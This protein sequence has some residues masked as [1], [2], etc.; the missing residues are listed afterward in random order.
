MPK[1]SKVPIGACVATSFGIGVLVGWRVED[2]C[3]VVRSLWQRRGTG[4][5]CGYLSR[6]SIHGVV[7]AAVGFRVQTTFGWGE[8]IAYVGGGPTFQN[9]HY[10]VAMKQ[11]NRHK[12]SVIEVNRKDILSCHGAQFIP[13]IEYIREAAHF[14]IQL[15][16][17]Q[18][19][20]REQ[21]AR[22]KDDSKAAWTESVWK[23]WSEGAEILWTSFLKAVEEDK[24][25]DDGVN[26]FMMSFIE[27]L[28]R[29]DGDTP[30]DEP[31][32]KE[33]DKPSSDVVVHS[34]FEV[35]CVA[36]GHGIPITVE[37]GQEPAFWIMNDFLGGIF[38]AQPDSKENST[39]PTR[40]VEPMAFEQRFNADGD[41]AIYYHR[42]FAVLRTLMKTISIARASSVENPDLRLGFAI[43]YDCL[44]FARTIVKVLRKN[45]SRH[46]MEVWNRAL[47]EIASTFGPIKER[48]EKIGQGIAQRMEKQGRRAKIRVLN[49]VDT[50]LGDERLILSLEQG[51]WEGALVR[52]EL[53]L[54]KSKIIE[55]ENLIYYRKAA[56][57]IYSH[58]QLAVSSDGGAATRNNQKL[59]ALAKAVQWIASPRRSVLKIFERNDVLDFFERILVRVFDKE[60]LASR[61][62]VIHASNFHSLRHLRLLKDVSTSGR[63]WMPVLDA[64][65]EE[66]SWVV[67]QLPENTKELISPLANL[68]SLC[69][70]EFHGIETGD[71]SADWMDFL[72]A[73]EAV[74]IIHNIDMKLI[75]ALEAFSRDVR[76]MM[77]VLPYYS[78]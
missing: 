60:E 63:L 32:R 18:A 4:A 20:L 24:E 62:L 47:E 11:D 27:F 46:S 78:R 55:K 1:H 26:S 12:G 25:F 61:M 16:T 3:H 21:E 39:S 65:D 35:E 17:Y 29:L 52:L 33:E 22:R 44:V 40:V 64:A 51:D 68:F 34:D 58:L 70:A 54:V 41:P 2:D 30:A 67:S 31:Q 6:N 42:A 48:L 75:L 57:F 66:F 71:S 74:Q 53:A 56:A 13:V 72:L 37:E 50:L 14:Q 69:V 10:I 73:D 36:S 43:C 49:F 28:E 15:D 38:N 5:A 9:G 8:T 45:E 7:E 77:L 23:M 59:A 76:E 19:A